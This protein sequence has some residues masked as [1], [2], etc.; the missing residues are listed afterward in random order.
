[1]KKNRL[2][3][4]VCKSV[5]A[6]LFSVWTLKAQASFIALSNT[7]YFQNFDSLPKNGKS[8][9]LP[10]GWSFAEFGQRDDNR[11]RADDGSKSFGGIYSYGLKGS[12]DRALGSL[13]G[14]DGTYGLFGASFQNASDVIINNL[15]LSFTGEEWRLGAAGR[16]DRLQFQYSLNASSLTSGTW[17]NAPQFDF[18]TPNT[19]GVGAHDGNLAVNQKQISGTISFLNIPSGG[20]FWIRWLD[21]PVSGGGPE[22]GLAI[23]NFSVSAVPEASTGLAGL[24][25]LG[26]LGL[27]SCRLPRF[28]RLS[29]KAPAH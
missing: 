5:L 28:L 10:Q 23:D 12:S 29:P 27:W 19:I 16:Q 1:M 6:L 4:V 24:V 26:A 2:F 22:D 14:A 20:T 18:L 21:A 13:R 3:K 9:D 11:I 25:G 15:K 8:S 7:N 17:I